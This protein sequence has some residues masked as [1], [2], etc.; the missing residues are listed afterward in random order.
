MT[1]PLVRSLEQLFS[2][3][4]V[5]VVG[6]SASPTKAGFAMMTA[7]AGVKRLHPVNPRTSE[8][9]GRVAYPALD[10]LPELVDLAVLTVPPTAVPDALAGCIAAGVGAA[11]V[12][13]GGFAESGPDGAALEKR[14]SGIV[15]GSGLRVLGPNT[16][17]FMNPA[18]GV[19]ANFMPSATKLSPGPVG[20]LAQSGGMNLAL[21]FLLNREGIGITVGVGLGNAIDVGFVDVLDHLATDSDTTVIAMH[22][23][24]ITQGRELAE[25]VSRASERKPVVAFKVGRNDVGDFARSH[26]GALTGDWA[27]TRAA[28]V[29]AGAVVVDGP[30][31]LVDAVGALAYRRLAPARRSRVAVVTGQ[32]GPGL[33][34]ADR[35]RDSAIDLP[36][37]SP[38]TTARL[39]ELLPPITY[40]R[41]P[42]DTGR[43][44]DS[45]VEVVRTVVADEAID[46]S[47]VYCLQEHNTDEIVRDLAQLTEPMVFI[48]GGL[49]TD[50]A[51]Q[52]TLLRA[53]NVPFFDAP[54]R[55]AVGLT[56]LVADARARALASPVPAAEEQT[57]VT[58]GVGPFDEDRA[59]RLLERLGIL[60]PRRIISDTHDGALAALEAL[61]A[62]V[63][64][65]LLDS[66]VLHKSDV[67]AVHVGVRDPDDMRNALAR[68]DAAV[69]HVARYLIERQA[70]PGT[71]LIVGAVRDPS[72]GPVVVLGVGG[73]DVET[74]ARAEMRLAP[75]RPADAIDLIDSLPAA[76]RRGSR[77]RPRIHDEE[78]AEVL[79]KI[80]HLMIHNP[81]LT[82]LEVNPLRVT[83][84]GLLA[85]D[86]VVLAA[87]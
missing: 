47:I 53:S 76:V 80:G 74:A 52:R 48:T 38:S 34:I 61:G 6:A 41:N 54:N 49:E 71:E 82:E 25:A 23:E 36:E 77:G 19:F 11:V 86:A 73:I 45:F 17:G 22:L 31:E 70:S 83:E 39:A 58:A 13:S 30:A 12:C 26:T 81:H 63:V 55:G 42:V 85:L 28:L 62:P 60:T 33:L 46:A 3:R 56:S 1:A 57:S 37:L 21:S 72:F 15:A 7:L 84:D 79:R 87:D 44:E 10:Q 66:T 5:A 24:G 64:V 32:A 78:L 27:L 65:K 35:L 8:I 20:V 9:A 51:E 67:G 2:P 29:Q 50:L 68:I 14:I 4:S 18:A 75:L 43:P 69:P 40:Q 59:K 16:S